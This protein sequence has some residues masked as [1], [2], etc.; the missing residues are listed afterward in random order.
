MFIFFLIPSDSSV[1]CILY[2]TES[3][4]KLVNHVQYN[5]HVLTKSHFL[6][7]SYYFEFQCLRILIKTLNVFVVASFSLAFFS[8]F[9][10]CPNNNAYK[11][12]CFLYPSN[13]SSINIQIYMKNMLKDNKCDCEGHRQYLQINTI[14]LLNIVTDIFLFKLVTLFPKCPHPCYPWDPSK[15]HIK[16]FFFF[17]TLCL[18]FSFDIFSFCLPFSFMMQ[19]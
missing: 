19:I 5:F 1:F 15:A 3:M 14:I 12:L 13:R 2:L 6:T 17:F 18:L 10:P 11:I 9:H 16:H 8:F 4:Q 7:S